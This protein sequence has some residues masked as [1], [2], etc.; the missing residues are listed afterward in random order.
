MKY[1]CGPL[2]DQRVVNLTEFGKV[3]IVMSGGIDSY[4]LYHLLKNPI[5]FNI[6]RADGFDTANRIRTLTGKDVIEVP[7][8]TTD[9]KSR[10][11][12]TIDVI[13]NRYP[14]DQLYIG[15]NRTPPDD[16]F[17]EFDTPNK[18]YRPWRLDG[19]VKAPFLHL[20]KYHI[21]D[22]AKKLGVNLLDTRSCIDNA[23]GDECGHCWQCKEKNW[24]FQQLSS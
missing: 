8:S 12:D 24:G 16:L 14:I 11:G 1:I 10:I 9:P 2:W 23:S 21:I 13:L 17:P 5:I 4:V 20:Y 15:I 3:G 22:L 18:P 6:A 7:E 19:V